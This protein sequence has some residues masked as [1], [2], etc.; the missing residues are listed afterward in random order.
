MAKMERDWL[1]KPKRRP[2]EV[3]APT[4]PES[5][6]TDSTME[7]KRHLAPPTMS[8]SKPVLP[9]R[10][11]TS[12]SSAQS[13]VN[14]VFARA[15]VESKQKAI[16]SAVIAPSSS[17][18]LDKNVA[19]IVQLVATIRIPQQAETSNFMDSTVVNSSIED[20]FD[21]S[22]YFSLKQSTSTPSQGQFRRK[23]DKLSMKK[24]FT[25]L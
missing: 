17:H 11:E 21:L 22:K 8:T 5:E 4:Q 18:K 13:V 12:E 7:S 9:E 3:K 25:K 14:K 6:H 1:S 24:T 19:G 15:P 16:A 20:Y 2:E 23:R 10:L